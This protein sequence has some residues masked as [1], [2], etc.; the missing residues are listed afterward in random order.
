MFDNFLKSNFTIKLLKK[1]MYLK[2]MQ[3]K[4]R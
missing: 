4:L 1:G 3:K 2:S